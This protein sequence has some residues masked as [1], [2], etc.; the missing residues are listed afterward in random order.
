MN[1]DTVLESFNYLEK[2]V[3]RRLSA[4][5]SYAEAGRAAGLHRSQVRDYL[6]GHLN[7]SYEKMY[8]ILTRLYQ[9]ES[10]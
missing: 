5:P 8:K 9:N 1:L 3:K 2:E 4:F 6:T 7:F 10:I